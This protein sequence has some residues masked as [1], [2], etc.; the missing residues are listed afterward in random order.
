MLD[1]RDYRD[2]D[3]DVLIAILKQNVPRYFADS[4]VPAFEAYLHKRQW[5]QCYVYLDAD[6][7]VIGCAGFY[8]KSP[9]V[10]GLSYVV[11]EPSKIGSGLIRT[12]LAKYLS[13]ASTE[14]CPLEEHTLVLNT[15]PRVARLMKRFGFV[16]TTTIPEGYDEGYDLVQMERQM[17]ST[18]AAT[19]IDNGSK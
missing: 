16:V 11:F 9:G 19:N 4:D 3:R 10:I 17:P 13:A 14:L 8:L 12:E 2:S 15:T 7:R 5:D 1:V 6:N 18:L